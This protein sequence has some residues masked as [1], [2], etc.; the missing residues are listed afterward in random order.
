MKMETGKSTD[1]LH[2]DRRFSVSVPDGAR[3]GRIDRGRDL[4]C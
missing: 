4:F 2:P 3:S 1:L